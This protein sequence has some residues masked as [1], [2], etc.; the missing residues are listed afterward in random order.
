MLQTALDSFKKSGKV[1]KCK[2]WIPMQIKSRQSGENYVKL[3]AAPPKLGGE[4]RYFDSYV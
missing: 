2:S 1:V 4:M 3:S